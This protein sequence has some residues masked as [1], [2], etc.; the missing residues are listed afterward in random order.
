MKVEGKFWGR[1]AVQQGRI[2]LAKETEG[3]TA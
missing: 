2:W 1:G 3:D